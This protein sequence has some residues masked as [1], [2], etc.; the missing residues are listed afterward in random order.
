MLHNI[1]LQLRKKD[2][3]AI[4]SIL[5]SFTQKKNSYQVSQKLERST[6]AQLTFDQTLSP[7]E[8]KL[9]FL[10]LELQDIK[11]NKGNTTL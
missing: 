3:E 9:K 8:Q 1:G 10:V 5:D 4:K 11:N 2:P 6:P 7:F